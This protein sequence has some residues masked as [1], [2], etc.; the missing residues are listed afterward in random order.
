[1]LLTV[2]SFENYLNTLQSSAK[3][4]EIAVEFN[5]LPP[6]PKSML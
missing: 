4:V 3:I 5:L 2:K 6:S 1:M